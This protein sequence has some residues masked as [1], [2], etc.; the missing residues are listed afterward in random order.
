MLRRPTTLKFFVF[1]VP[2]WTDRVLWR[3]PKETPGQLHWYGRAE[4]K[5]S[6]HRP[7]LSVID[8][9]VSKI[10]P[11][12]REEVFKDALETCG[13]PDGSVLL[14]VPDNKVNP[15]ITICSKKGP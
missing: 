12:K 7:V 4:L 14:Q 10:V 13:P 15:L 1:R 5:Q 11:D 8:I 2:A 3:G 6:D 9:E